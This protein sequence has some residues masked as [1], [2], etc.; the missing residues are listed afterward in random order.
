MMTGAKLIVLSGR[1]LACVLTTLCSLPASYIDLDSAAGA[2]RLCSRQ[3]MG[4]SPTN[5]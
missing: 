3:S 5:K 2:K 1:L 4:I